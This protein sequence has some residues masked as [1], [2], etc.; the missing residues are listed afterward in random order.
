MHVY[1]VIKFS[2]C[3]DKKIAGQMRDFSRTQQ[4]PLKLLYVKIFI[5]IFEKSFH[6]QKQCC[7]LLLTIVVI[8]NVRTALNLSWYAKRNPHTHR[9]YL[10]YAN[11]SR[12][13]PCIGIANKKINVNIKLRLGTH[14]ELYLQVLTRQKTL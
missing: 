9:F 3:F 12:R 7:L 6:L 1:K 14:V 8:M 5:S 2:N 10:V 11:M 13:K 4:C